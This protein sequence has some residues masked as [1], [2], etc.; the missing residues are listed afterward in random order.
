[1][2]GR[3]SVSVVDAEGRASGGHRKSSGRNLRVRGS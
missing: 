3:A 2:W 1:M